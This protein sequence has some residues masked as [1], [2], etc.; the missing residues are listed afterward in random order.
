LSDRDIFFCLKIIAF[1]SIKPDASDM[2]PN[3]MPFSAASSALS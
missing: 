2:K 1:L 3:A